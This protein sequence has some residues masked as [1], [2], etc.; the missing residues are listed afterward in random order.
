[1]LTLQRG[2]SVGYCQVGAWCPRLIIQ[3]VLC[4]V[5]LKSTLLFPCNNMLLFHCAVGVLKKLRD[6]K[7]VLAESHNRSFSQI[8][9]LSLNFYPLSLFSIFGM[10]FFDQSKTLKIVFLL[11]L[12]FIENFFIRIS[13]LLEIL[14]IG[15]LKFL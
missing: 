13:H 1:M 10:D 8:L 7:K 9:L 2:H 4:V 14:K 3:F 12:I 6:G 11:L 5:G 15:F